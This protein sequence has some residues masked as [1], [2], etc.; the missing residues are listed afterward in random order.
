[1]HFRAFSAGEEGGDDARL[2]V[3]QVTVPVDV[4]ATVI[5]NAR[6]WLLPAHII[7]LLPRPSPFA[8]VWMNR[9]GFN[10]QLTR[11]D[12]CTCSVLAGGYA[13]SDPA[14]PLRIPLRWEQVGPNPPHST[15]AE[16]PYGFLHPARSNTCIYL[17]VVRLCYVMLCYV[18]CN[19]VCRRA[20]GLAVQFFRWGAGP[21]ARAA[22]GDLS[23]PAVGD[24]PLYILYLTVPYR[25]LSHN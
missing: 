3:G 17:F 20:D 15:R 22:A 23:D 25:I 24:C 8:I 7:L 2:L 16:P 12:A 18:L 13:P 19:I 4:P 9:A 14:N 10:L 1:M 21:R 6:E 11:L 5:L